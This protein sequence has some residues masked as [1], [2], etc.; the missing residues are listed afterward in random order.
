MRLPRRLPCIISVLLVALAAAG[1]AGVVETSHASAEEEANAACIAW[2]EAAIIPLADR[3][4][5]AAKLEV[6]YAHARRAGEGSADYRELAHGFAGFQSWTRSAGPAIADGSA[7]PSMLQEGRRL[8]EQAVA[9]CVAIG[10]EN[11]SNG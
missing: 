7:T 1:C 10:L 2:D 11:M 5:Y 6:A 9:P 4:G 3:A 8:A